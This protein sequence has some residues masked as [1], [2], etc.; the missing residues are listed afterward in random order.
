MRA[1]LGV[2]SG[3]EPSLER[4]YAAYPATRFSLA[5]RGYLARIHPLELWL[6]SF[7]KVHPEASF[8]DAVAASA[9]QRQAVYRWL[10]ASKSRRAQD[11]R[12]G[13]A[14]EAE[15]FERIAA[16]WRRLG[17]PFE[18]L[19]P[20]FATAI[21]VSADRPANL[22]ELVAVV[23]NGGV[24][25]PRVLIET[26]HFAAGTPFETLLEREPRDGERVLQADVAEAARRALL[27]VVEKGTARRLKGVYRDAAGE[28]LP[29][30]G[31][32]GTGDH[33]YH[34][35]GPGG[36]LKS[37]QVV[38]RAAVFTFFIGDRFFG[39]VTAFV[40]GSQAAGYDFTSAL[41]VQ[42]MKELEPTLR[43]LL[44]GATAAQAH[45][46]KGAAP[47]RLNCARAVDRRPGSVQVATAAD[48]ARAR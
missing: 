47:G 19:V 7:R 11:V 17:Y 34:V 20:S 44:A 18:H 23:S 10:F 32:T 37:S 14:L 42:I 8:A 36:R 38:N 46:A 5:D 35:F 15:A 33:R 6:A 22:A 39:T 3:G 16:T 27:G 45:Q 31:K 48:L 12:I 25:R 43:P 41:A 26:V 21:G 28:L 40:P 29:L 13:I 30:G 24:R 1:H 2:R 4:L 9:P